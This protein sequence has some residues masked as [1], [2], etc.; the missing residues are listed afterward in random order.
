[1]KYYKINAFVPI[2]L[3]PKVEESLRLINVPGITVSKVKGYGGSMNLYTEDW[4]E[5]HGRIEIFCDGNVVDSICE[6]IQNSLCNMDVS[7]GFI[8]ILP[9][10]R[11]FT[12]S[13]P[14][15]K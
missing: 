8:A 15:D 10:E 11:M 4:M 13:C 1:M 7:K 9:V 6:T 5:T 3:L 14:I 12:L 2:I